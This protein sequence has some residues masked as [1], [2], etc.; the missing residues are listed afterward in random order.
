MDGLE[1]VDSGVLA[2]LERE[3]GEVLVLP[4]ALL[5]EGAGEGMVL[6]HDEAEDHWECQPQEAGARREQ[7][8]RRL[9]AL[10]RRS[11]RGLKL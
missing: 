11:A 10:N 1:A 2:R 9:N 4:A 3:D 5:P 8:Q 7:A 6:T